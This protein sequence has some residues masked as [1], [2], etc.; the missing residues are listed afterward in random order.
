VIVRVVV[1]A[2]LTALVALLGYGVVLRD[3]ASG[4]DAAVA[5]GRRPAA[6]A[7]SLP[8]LGRRAE[9]SLASYRGRVVVL[10]FWASWCE[11]CRDE[12]P[13]LERWHRR[14][15]HRGATVVGVD[16]MDVDS[17]AAAFARRYRLTYPLLHDGDGAGARAF[18]TRGFP[19]TFVIDRRGRVA[20]LRRGP[21]DDVFLERNV[22]PLLREGA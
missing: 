15:A 18:G 20:A 3:E 13:L 10:N 17:D 11:P 22:R 5:A 7:L 1:V 6:P 14:L 16:A 21:V 19:E 4:L 2:L 12:S 9:R 8:V